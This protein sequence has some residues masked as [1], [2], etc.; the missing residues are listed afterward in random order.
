VLS[1]Q[2]IVRSR[3][4]SFDGVKAELVNPKSLPETAFADA[5]LVT[6]RA[7]YCKAAR[8]RADIPSHLLRPRS[9]P[10]L[11]ITSKTERR[12]RSR[13]SSPLRPAAVL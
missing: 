4:S 7:A 11:R 6:I 12:G 5:L 1:P 8:L 9:P 13:R 10:L 3:P 2:P